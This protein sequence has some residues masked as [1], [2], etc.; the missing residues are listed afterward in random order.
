MC[1]TGAAGCRDYSPVLSVLATLRCW[2]AVGWERAHHYC[3][4]TLHDAVTTLT[5]A[6]GTDTL[7]PLALCAHMALVRVPLL[8]C[9]PLFIS[10]ATSDHACAL[11]VR[12]NPY[13]LP[14][15]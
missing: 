7:V 2:D 5:S 11:Q 14:W 15:P 9:P 4:A 8:R 3:R 6:W 10:T 12:A 1:A 13:P